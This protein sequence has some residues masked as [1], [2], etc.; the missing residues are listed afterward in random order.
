MIGVERFDLHL[1]SVYSVDSGMRVQ[2]LLDQASSAGLRGL[3]LTDHNSIEGHARLFELAPRYPRLILVP[4]VEV[5]TAEGHLLVYGVQEAPPRGP[6]LA[7]AIDWATR[8]GYAAVL[9]HPF[10]LFHG[11]GRRH[12]ETARV[13]ALEAVNGHTGELA[14][15]KAELLAAQRSL[16]T[17]GGSDAHAPRDVG[18]AF[19]EFAD[20]VERADDVVDLLRRGRCHASGRS[21]RG[22]ERIWVPLRHAGRRVAR[23]FRPV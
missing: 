14:N 13:S 12:S 9:A 16:G 17:T 11:A 8:R 4:G 6:R 7:E 18:R 21:L 19:T 23:G 10:R 2:A 15:A 3:A 20:S 22:G 1:H 5:S